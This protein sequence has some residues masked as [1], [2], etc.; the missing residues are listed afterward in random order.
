MVGEMVFGCVVPD[1]PVWSMNLVVSLATQKRYKLI[2]RS[3]IRRVIGEIEPQFTLFVN[4]MTLRSAFQ[5][6]LRGGR[7]AFATALHR[8]S[9]ALGNLSRAT[10]GR[11]VSF[12]DRSAVGSRP[13]LRE[14]EEK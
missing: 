9:P 12:E 2:R 8:Q 11:P 7:R 6:A 13:G 5:E 14:Q 10:G 1:T 4:A 3:L